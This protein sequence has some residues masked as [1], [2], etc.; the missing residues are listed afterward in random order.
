[1]PRDDQRL[2]KKYGIRQNQSSAAYNLLRSAIISGRFPQGTQL[3]ERCLAEEFHVSRTPLRHALTKLAAEGIVEQVPHVGSFVRKL[4]QQEVLLLL[5]CR[6][7]I[8]SGAAALAAQ[9]LTAGNAAEL[10]RLAGE[11]E[12]RIRDGEPG[13]RREAELHFHNRIIELAENVE[14]RRWTDEVLALSLAF[15]PVKEKTGLSTQPD[16]NIYG[17]H[18]TIAKAIVSRDPT[19]AFTAMWEHFNESIMKLTAQ[20]EE[21]TRRSSPRREESSPRAEN[22]AKIRP[23]RRLG[24]KPPK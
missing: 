14:I 15:P 10:L 20:I 12:T 17:I 11:V 5:E 8:E 1:M 19:K 13:K 24:Q 16:L 9:K 23:G 21:S 4:E 7:A 18:D 2:L 6:R 22:A 3:N